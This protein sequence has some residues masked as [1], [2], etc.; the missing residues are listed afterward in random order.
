MNRARDTGAGRPVDATLRLELLRLRGQVERAEAA[1]AVASLRAG[2]APIAGVLRAT[3]G[4]RQW[5]AAIAARPQRS[6]WFALL[7]WRTLR[8]H[9]RLVL[10]VA[11]GGLALA[12]LARRRAPVADPTPPDGIHRDPPPDP[13]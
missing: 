13:R 5:L 11:G 9:P 4:G 1:G 3:R 2:L 8:R 7:A 6:W 12:W 10:A